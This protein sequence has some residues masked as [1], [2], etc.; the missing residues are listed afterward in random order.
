[1]TKV[2]IKKIGIRFSDNDFY[3]TLYG[4]FR[5]LADGVLW[6]HHSLPETLTKARIVQLFNSTNYALY[7]L[8][9]HGF[10]PPHHN[11][12]EEEDQQ[13]ITTWLTIT[14][15]NVYFNEEVDQYVDHLRTSQC[16]NSEFQYFDLEGTLNQEMAGQ[17]L[18]P[19][20]NII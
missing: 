17:R 12:T 15:E 16:G 3:N 11:R 8:Y 14:E 20:I 10:R 1:M 13:R 5:V 19:V 4:F 18:D 6:N 9:Q 7:Q 2:E